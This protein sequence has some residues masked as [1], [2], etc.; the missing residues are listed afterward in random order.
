M[1]KFVVPVIVAVVV[2]AG[3]GEYL[4]SKNLLFLNQQKNR[5]G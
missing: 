2:A 4:F 1:N 3:I 5:L